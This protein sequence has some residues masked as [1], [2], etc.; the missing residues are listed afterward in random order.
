MSET[1]HPS[2]YPDECLGISKS[3]KLVREIILREFPDASQPQNLP[4]VPQTPSRILAIPTPGSYLQDDP[5]HPPYMMLRCVSVINPR[6][7]AQLLAA[8]DRVQL[9][10][11]A[12]HIKR[13]QARSVTPAY[14]WGVWEAN[15]STPFITRESRKQSDEA[16][17]A[18]DE[19]LNLVRKRV[20]PK[21]IELS[22]HYLPL[23]WKEQER[24][25]TLRL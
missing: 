21:V 5:Q 22:R 20:V 13:E 19:L 17:A 8:W 11:P 14:H 24:L 25:V 16:V 7:Q 3:C 1:Y 23:Q 15:A 10:S 4:A 18:I 12:H 9:V 6:T 2:Q